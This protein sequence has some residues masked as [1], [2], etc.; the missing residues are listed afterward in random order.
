MVRVE[1]VPHRVPIRIVVADD[2]E[3]FAHSL[4]TLLEDDGRFEVVGVAANGEQAVQLAIWHE[5]DVVVMDIR[6][7][8]ID[9]IEA[10]RLLRRSRP[11]ACVLMMSGDR[12]ERSREA[13]EA[14]ASSVLH[15]R[16]FGAEMIDAIAT[17]GE[18]S[19]AGR[20]R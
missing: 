19:R 16:T 20:Q 1:R 18:R 15:K 13:L 17:A 5:P 6:M 2:D 7:P 11:R 3:A 14:G 4:A 9:G 10:T 8:I 12:A